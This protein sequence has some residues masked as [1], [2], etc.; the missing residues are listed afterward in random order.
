MS[1]ADPFAEVHT[2]KALEE[3]VSCAQLGQSWR[4]G[5]F[6]LQPCSGASAFMSLC[7]DCQQC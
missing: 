3:M 6:C 1:R 4:E 7:I 5:Q 2:V